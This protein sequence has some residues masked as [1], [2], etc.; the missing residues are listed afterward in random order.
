MRS[1]KNL[2]NWYFLWDF[3][4]IHHVKFSN[5][6]FVRSQFSLQYIYIYFYLR[7]LEI[8]VTNNIS[9]DL[10]E[11]LTG[12]VLKLRFSM[13]FSWDLFEKWSSILSSDS[14]Q[15]S[16]RFSLDLVRFLMRSQMRSR[17][18]LYMELYMIRKP[19]MICR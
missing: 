18:E 6:I 17:R 8:F 1:N 13:E 10:N 3:N 2:M 4:K 9:W 19:I 16:K 7:S 14:H 15:F 5:Q 12:I 11:I